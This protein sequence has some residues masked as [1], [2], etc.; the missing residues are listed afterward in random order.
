LTGH[1]TGLS[2]RPLLIVSCFS[3][4]FCILNVTAML[5]ANSKLAD[6]VESRLPSVKNLILRRQSCFVHFISL[7]GTFKYSHERQAKKPAQIVSFET[8]IS[9]SDT[10]LFAN[11]SRTINGRAFCCTSLG[12]SFIGPE[13]P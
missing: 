11:S 10:C 1:K 5:S 9:S 6:G 13:L 7:R 8:P 3:S 4:F 12:S 2:V